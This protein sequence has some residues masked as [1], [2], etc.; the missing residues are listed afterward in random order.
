MQ[1]YR[2]FAPTPMDPYGLNLPDRQEW[3]VVIGQNRDSNA[4][5]ESNFASALKSLGGE[6]DHVQ[7]YRFGHWA[8]GWFEVLLI[9]PGHKPAVSI[10]ESIE[11]ALADYPVLDDADVSERETTEANEVWSSCYTEKQRVQYIRNHRDQFEF[12]DFSDMLGC[13]R[14][15]YFSGYAS[16]LLE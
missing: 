9:D 16:E 12:R 8:C 6:G 11:A 13:C 4:V 2:E 3:L 5:S 10:A 14:G 15:N 7:V 1:S